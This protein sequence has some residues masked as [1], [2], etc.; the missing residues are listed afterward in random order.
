MFWIELL[1]GWTAGYAFLRALARWYSTISHLG[2]R[3]TLLG[4]AM[5]W[6]LR[7]ASLFS[8]S[9]KPYDWPIPSTL[10]V[11]FELQ[12]ITYLFAGYWLFYWQTGW[13]PSV[14]LHSWLSES[15]SRYGRGLTRQKVSF[16]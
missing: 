2:D 5:M 11:L 8:T 3:K 9:S 16:R 15:L 6:R 12:I 4:S 13:N 1:I 7:T 14:A 10:L